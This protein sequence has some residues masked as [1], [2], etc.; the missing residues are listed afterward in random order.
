[1]TQWEQDKITHN[2]LQYTQLEI[3]EH[4]PQKNIDESRSAGRENNICCTRGT[5]GV[6]GIR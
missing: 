3:G 4:E 1:M 2:Y 5:R 6:T